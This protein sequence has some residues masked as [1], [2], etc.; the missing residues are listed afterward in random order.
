[1][2]V[3][4]NLIQTFLTEPFDSDTLLNA[5]RSFTPMLSS[6]KL[7]SR[8]LSS[9]KL[10]SRKLSSRKLSSRKDKERDVSPQRGLIAKPRVAQRTLGIETSTLLNPNGVSSSRCNPVGVE[11]NLYRS[12]PGCA[13]RPWPF[14]FNP[15]GIVVRNS[16]F[17]CGESNLNERN[18]DKV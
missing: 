4:F 12:D 2:K 13:S 8:K 11:A 15:V 10:S 17:L 16:R 9:R 7:S 18:W 14:L 1:M 6:R 5:S 3:A